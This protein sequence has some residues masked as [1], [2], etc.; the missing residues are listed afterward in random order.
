MNLR[1]QGLEQLR[2]LG[3]TEAR[4]RMHR[5]GPNELPSTKPR[6]VLAIASEVFRQPMFLLLVGCGLV[7]LVFGNLQEALVLL[8]FVV[9]VMGITFYQER[10]TER[11]L[12]AL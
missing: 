2:G 7:Y 5:D 11:A 8:A 3:E 1:A 6:S 4:A 10:K 9:I 12:D